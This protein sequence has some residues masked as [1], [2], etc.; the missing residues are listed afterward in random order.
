VTPE[1]FQVFFAL[2]SLG[3]LGVA[4]LV[5]L[6]RL[7]RARSL[8]DAVRPLALP[9][10]AVITATATFGSL[11][12]SEIAG[13]RPCRLCWYQRAAMYPLAAFLVAAAVR[14]WA[15]AWR[16]AVPV[17]IVGAA[18]AAYHWFLERFPDLDSGSCDPTVPCTVP[19]FSTFGFMS[20]AFMAW[21][22]FAATIALVT[23]RRAP[24]P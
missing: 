9:L 12:F 8:L 24:R 18:V 17:A 3:A 10:A 6:A 5:P 13:Y 14:R 15:W 16:A 23:L 11:Y 22:A 21:T 4:I 19:Y 7:A 2:L 20:L 1:T